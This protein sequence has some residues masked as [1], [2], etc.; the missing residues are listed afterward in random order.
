MQFSFDCF[1]FI[2]AWHLWREGKAGEL[3][4]PSMA[5]SCSPDEAL[6][7]IHVG[8]LCIQDDPSKR[9]L[10]SSVVSILENGSASGTSLLSL[11]TPNQPAYLAMMGEKNSELENSRNTMA[12][13]VIQG[14]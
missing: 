13:T 10:M 4:D 9:P 12:M 8:L 7:C 2:Q 14:R 5:G 6:L 3:L 11:P 1:V